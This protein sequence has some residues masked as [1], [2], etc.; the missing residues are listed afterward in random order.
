MLRVILAN[1]HASMQRYRGF[2]TEAV[3]LD[4]DTTHLMQVFA[5]HE[6]ARQAALSSTLWALYA[7]ERRQGVVFAHD[8]L[9]V[10]RTGVGK[11][12]WVYFQYNSSTPTYFYGVWPW[13]CEYWTDAGPYVVGCGGNIA[14]ANVPWSG[15]TGACCANARLHADS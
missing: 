3:P 5:R 1:A 15:G 9:K 7:L 10:T 13:G 4:A 8:S 2:T 14:A 11:G 6:W 12:E